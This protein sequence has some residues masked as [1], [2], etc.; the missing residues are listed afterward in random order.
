MAKT[1]HAK[2]IDYFIGPN[3]NDVSLDATRIEERP[4]DALETFDSPFQRI[5]YFPTRSDAMGEVHARAA[6]WESKGYSITY[7]EKT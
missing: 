6:Y 1:P 5:Q 7:I 3:L 2:S 4:V